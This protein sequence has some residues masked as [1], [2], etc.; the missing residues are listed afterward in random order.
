MTMTSLLDAAYA[1]LEDVLKHDDV[2][3]E[4]LRRRIEAMLLEIDDLRV[5][6]MLLGPSDDRPNL[7]RPKN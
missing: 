1:I 3:D 5:K 4:A 6:A 7:D 2:R